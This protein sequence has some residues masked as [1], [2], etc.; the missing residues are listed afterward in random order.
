MAWYEFW[1]AYNNTGPYANV[2]IGGSPN[3][4]GPYGAPLTEAHNAGYG[5][6]IEFT[7][8]GSYGVTFRLN[9]V[10]YAVTDAQQYLANSFYVN[11]GGN[12]RYRLVIH[13]SNDNQ[14]TWRQ[15]YSNFVFSH[16]SNWNL[17]YL[18]NWHQ[19]AQA[20]QWSQFFQLPRDTTH[21]RIELM[22]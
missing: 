10:G 2:V 9:L 7:D 5:R 11:F 13:I 15:I 17:L 6:G 4:T 22:G 18:S 3:A 14:A 19:V 1:G 16:P 12:Y 21:V 20:S 8:N